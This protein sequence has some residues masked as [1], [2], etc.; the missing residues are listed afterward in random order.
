MV[1]IID[2]TVARSE[3]QFEDRELTLEMSIASDLP[4][5]EADPEVLQRVLANLL[6]NACLASTVGGRVQLEVIHSAVHPLAGEEQDPV[7]GGYLV[8]SVTDSGGGLSDAA[9]ERAFDRSRPSQTPPGLG[10]SGAGL[11]LAKMMIEEGGGDLWAQSEE[12]KGTSFSF[13]VP[14]STVEQSPGPLSGAKES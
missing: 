7:S 10:E 9:L 8:V 2:S 1:E 4:V 12:G 6:S 11:A 5:I 3:S 13:A 14:A